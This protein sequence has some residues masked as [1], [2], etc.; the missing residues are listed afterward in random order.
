[1][2]NECGTRDEMRVKKRNGEMRARCGA[3]KPDKEKKERC[4]CLKEI[5]AY[6]DKIL[7]V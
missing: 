5:M 3:G 2:S 7:S 6:E 4:V 1:M